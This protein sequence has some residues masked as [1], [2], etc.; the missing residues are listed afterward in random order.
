[1]LLLPFTLMT[2]P[3]TK[4]ASGLARVGDLGGAAYRDHRD[5]VGEH[6]LEPLGDLPRESRG[7]LRVVV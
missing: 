6:H 3:V 7:V 4:P 5:R 1:M 2:W